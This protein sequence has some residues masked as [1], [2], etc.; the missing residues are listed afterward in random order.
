MNRQQRLVLAIG[1]GLIT[2][3]G[4]FP[5]YEAVGITLNGDSIKA[6]M[7]FR[8]IF[9]AP[10]RDDACRAIGHSSSC[11]DLASSTLSRF[12]SQIIVSQLWAQLAVVSLATIALTVCCGSRGTDYGRTRQQNAAECG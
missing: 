5:P 10:L 2:L 12:H 11:E 3:C 4:L 8:F 9:A 6:H 1:S 7:G